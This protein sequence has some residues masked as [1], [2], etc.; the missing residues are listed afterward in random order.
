MNKFIKKILVF[1]AVFALVGCQN[2]EEKELSQNEIFHNEI[3]KEINEIDSLIAE[4]SFIEY[5]VLE[6]INN[7][8]FIT[9]ERM[10]KD[11]IYYEK[12]RVATGKC[13]I[14]KQIEDKVYK[15]EFSIMDDIIYPEYMGNIEDFEMEFPIPTMP[16]NIFN[17]E[18]FN[19]IKK[20]NC[21]IIEGLFEDYLE[22]EKTEHIKNICTK[23]RFSEE[24]VNKSNVVIKYEFLEKAL[25][26]TVEV[27]I[28]ANV[29]NKL[30]KDYVINKTYTVSMYE[31]IEFDETDTKYTI[32]YPES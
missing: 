30:T 23:L 2:Q 16:N 4:S 12:F 13:L 25:K 32:K 17:F 3:K 22:E 14:Y 26:T 31:F 7:V 24:D 19:I 9:I 1:F 29:N 8:E 20:E 18:K 6:R 11:K 5:R 21:Y 28:K 27:T 15:F 10:R